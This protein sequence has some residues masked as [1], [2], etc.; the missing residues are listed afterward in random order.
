MKKLLILSVLALPLLIISCNNA[1][2][3]A[4]LKQHI[5]DSIKIASLQSTVANV[6]QT[7]NNIVA[8]HNEKAQATKLIDVNNY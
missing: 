1:E 7:T 2:K 6:Q 3:E 4:Q 5:Q 8:A